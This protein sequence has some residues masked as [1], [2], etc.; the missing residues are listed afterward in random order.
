MVF[1]R[2]KHAEAGAVDAQPRKSLDVG[3]LFPSI[4]RS[5]KS[6]DFGAFRRRQSKIF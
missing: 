6:F 5:R 1:R 2:S 3:V 4:R